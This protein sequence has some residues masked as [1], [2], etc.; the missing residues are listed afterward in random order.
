MSR[1][2]NR[3]LGGFNRTLKKLDKLQNKNEAKISGHYSAIE[4]HKQSISA[5][6]QMI[7]EHTYE[8]QQA[9]KIA[10][11]IRSLIS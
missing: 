10:D 8:S 3:I 2:L 1:K 11:K 5:R 4:S 9:A 6:E 7:D